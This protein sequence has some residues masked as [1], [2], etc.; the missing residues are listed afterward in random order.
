MPKV[1][2]HGS[3]GAGKSTFATLLAQEVTAAGAHALRLK[4]GAPLYEL[5]AIVYA[6]AGR[7]LLD[8]GDQDGQLLNTLG[9]HLRRINPDALTEVFTRRVRQAEQIKPQAVLVCDDLRAADVEA[10]TGLGFDLVEI[11]APKPLRMARK[12]ARGDLSPGDEDHLPEVPVAAASRWS[13][14]NI[15]SLNDLRERAAQIA[16]EI[17]T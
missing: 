10:V 5:Q 3:P 9:S 16:A 11:T 14:D 4:L 6:M 13:V 7:P 1:A 8:G 2:L 17:L 12:R 15:G